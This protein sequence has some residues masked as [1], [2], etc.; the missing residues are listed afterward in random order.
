MFRNRKFDQ[1]RHQINGVI[2]LTFF[3]VFSMLFSSSSLA[4]LIMEYEKV[5][6]IPTGQDRAIRPTAVSCDPLTGDI[7]V[8]DAQYSTFHV[9]NK[10]GIEIFKTS[11]FAR[12]SS[13][14]DGS[15]QDSGDF[16]FTG[17]N[18][19][20]VSTIQRLD[21]MGEPVEFVP[22][23]PINSWEPRHLAITR[24]NGFLTL[25]SYHNIL[26]KHDSKTG[27]LLWFTKVADA[28]SSDFQLGRPVEAPDGRIYLPSGVLHNVFVFSETGEQ[29][30]TFGIFGTGSSKMVFPVGVAIGPEGTILVLDRMRHK[31]LMFDPDHNFL[32]EFGSLGAGLGQFYHPMAIAAS[33]DGKVYVAQGYG[34]RVQ[35]YNIR[36]TKAD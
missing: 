23:I 36:D 25:D 4:T 1:K 31:V 3:L 11:G 12:L 21:F 6:N 28:G 8:T 22:E 32:I 2:F 14:G 35:V 29:L 27:A 18:Q 20:G 30:E 26:A 19:G 5:L 33:K 13:P 7:C 10:H 15:L 34:S 9:L 17:K 24:D 16:V